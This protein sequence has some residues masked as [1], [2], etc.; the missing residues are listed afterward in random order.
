MR[1]ASIDIGTHTI[2]L[3]IAEYR[4]GSLVPIL[5]EETFV[6]LGEGVDRTRHLKPEAM[7]RGLACLRRYIAMA[8]EAEA[9]HIVACGTSALRDAHNRRAFIERVQRELALTIRV[10]T[11]EEEA[12]LSFAGTLSNTRHLPPPIYVLDI[13]GGSTELCWGDANGLQGRFSL[14]I[15]SVRLTER[16]LRHDPPLEAELDAVRTT[17]RDAWTGE[18]LTQGLQA[19][20]LTGVDGT[21]TTFAAM[22]QALPAYD[23]KRI[24]GFTLS[25]QQLIEMTGTLVRMPIAGRRTITGLAPE[26]AEVM[27]A[28][29]LIL[30]EL[31][32]LLRANTLIV[33]DTGLRYGLALEATRTLQVGVN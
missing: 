12:R 24:D 13:G 28:G 6:R 22:A 30:C 31:M 7:A 14:N 20:T 10:I 32:H 3:L 15:G 26:R 29:A 1:L 19:G 17:I 4:D 23:R 2:L 9:H 25:L 11:G 8:R 21:A 33:S 5:Q 16:W 18:P 27:P